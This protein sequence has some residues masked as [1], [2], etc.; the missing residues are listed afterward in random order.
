M[1]Y[2]TYITLN[3]LEPFENK[4]EAH[5]WE[6]FYIKQYNTLVSNS[7][8]NLSPTG[9]MEVSGTHSESTRKQISNSLKK[10]EKFKLSRQ[11][12]VYKEKQR[13]AHLGKVNSVEARKKI[14]A[15]NKGKKRYDGFNAGEKNSFYGKKHTAETRAKLSIVHKGKDPWN[16]GKHNIYSEETKKKISEGA[17]SRVVS[18]ETRK[19]I[20]DSHKGNTYCLGNKL[21]DVHKKNISTALLIAFQQKAMNIY[22]NKT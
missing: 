10:S 17:R 22:K 6:G 4:D 14:S 3:L 9:G 12:I 20:S 13:L 7:G 1:T 15:S 19:K 11:S 8:Y 18:V 21:T 16:K 2:Y 5:F